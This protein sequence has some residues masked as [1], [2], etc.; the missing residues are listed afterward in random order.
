MSYT[1]GQAARAVGKSK[2]T[3]SRAIDSG[4][5]SAMRN[6]DGSYL[7]D[8]AELHRVF[9]PI[10]SATVDDQPDATLRDPSRERDAIIEF[11]VLQERLEG[12]QRELRLRDDQVRDLNNRLDEAHE[13]KM[14]LTAL[15]AAPIIVPEGVAATG[16]PHVMTQPRQ[17]FFSRLFDRPEE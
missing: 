1:V 10:R 11:R 12:A 17:G 7:I 8:A 14:R 15:L 6:D 16:S 4:R 13:E 5:I 9:P 2:S 3:I